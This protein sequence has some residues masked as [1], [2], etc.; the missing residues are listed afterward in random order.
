MRGGGA[1]GAEKLSIGRL[2]PGR[3]TRGAVLGAV[4]GAAVGVAALLIAFAARAGDGDGDEADNAAGAARA[5]QLPGPVDYQLLSASAGAEPTGLRAD[6]DALAR[7]LLPA[8]GRGADGAM[9]PW[10]RPLLPHIV[11]RS[12]Q[13]SARALSYQLIFDHEVLDPHP[14]FRASVI[15]LNRPAA[16]VLPRPLSLEAPAPRSARVGR[17]LAGMTLWWFSDSDT[18]ATQPA[19][20]GA[21]R[22]RLAPGATAQRSDCRYRVG[23]ARGGGSLAY[24][25]SGF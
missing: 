23:A 12:L 21:E 24:V 13:E 16:P 1:T 11:T 10:A 4:L 2:T 3:A 19:L 18:A 15:D 14:V 7:G 17:V 5:V 20:A 25:C 8:L 22:Y 9:Q 6:L